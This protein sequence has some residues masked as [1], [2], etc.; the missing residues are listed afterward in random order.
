MKKLLATVGTVLVIG[1]LAGGLTAALAMGTASEDTNE[2][3]GPMPLEDALAI[4]EGSACVLDGT[5]SG[6]GLY[7]ENTVTWW[8]DLDLDKPGCN[9]ACV[10]N[11]ETEEAEINWRCTGAIPANDDGDV[12]VPSLNG[13]TTAE[14]AIAI[15]QMSE[16]VAD[17]W[18]TGEAFHNESTGTWWLDLDVKKEGCAP[19]CVVN[20]ETGVAEIN[21]RCTGAL[22]PTDGKV[23]VGV[24]LVGSVPNPGV[25]VSSHVL[26]EIG[27]AVA[28]E[29]EVI[30]RSIEPLPMD[31][32]DNVSFEN[33]LDIAERA[34]YEAV[35][36]IAD[37]ESLRLVHTLTARCPFCWALEFEINTDAGVFT[38]SVMVQEGKVVNLDVGLKP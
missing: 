33:S 9:P 17:G 4:A 25:D 16:C 1:G 31:I 28:P 24:P 38:A 3:V 23:Q 34:V 6:E 35:R 22:P 21:W 30:D 29:P 14:E 27:V 13:S 26:P 20:V 5:L 2:S 7:N 15:A 11:V 19:A 10:V 32:I 18:F 36:E 8:L 37:V 12:S